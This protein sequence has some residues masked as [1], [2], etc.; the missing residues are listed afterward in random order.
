MKNPL[1]KRF[2]RE[3]LGDF[4]KYAVIFILLV[5]MIGYCSGFFVAGQSMSIAYDESFELYNIEDGHV[6]FT[7]ELNKAQRKDIENLGITLY[8]NYYYDTSFLNDTTIRL[9]VQRDEVNKICL[10]D[11]ELP[12]HGEIGLDR[13]YAVN[14]NLSIGDTI[15]DG[16]NTYTISGLVALSD[17]SALFSDNSDMMFDAVNFGVAVLT[18]EDFE[19]ISNIPV[20][21]Y[22][23]KWNQ[24]IEDEKELHSLNEDL[25]KEINSIV[26]VKDFIA[27]EDNQAITFTGEDIGGDSQMVVVFLYMVIVIVAFVMT[28]TINNTIVKESSVIGT[29]RATGYT[30]KELV[31]HYATLPILVSIASAVIGNIIGY[32]FMVDLNADLYYS[33]YSLPTFHVLF[34][35]S[36]FI[37][38]TI[39]PLIL[40]VVIVYAMLW[41]AL[42]L[43]PLQFIRKDLRRKKKQ[44]TLKLNHHIPFF[45]RFRTRVILSNMPNYIVLFFGI[46]FSNLLLYF[47]LMLPDALDNYKNKIANNLL[48]EYQTMLTVPSDVLYNSSEIETAIKYMNFMNEVET[49]NPTAE[50]FSAYSLQIPQSATKESV[51]IYGISINSKYVSIDP[52]KI[53]VSSA[54][55]KKYKVSIG[56]EIT[57]KEEYEDKNYIFHVDEIYNYDGAIAIFMDQT[58]LNKTFGYNKDFFCGYFS[59][60]PITDINEDYIGNVIDLQELTKVSTQLDVSMGEMMKMVEGFALLIFIVVTYLLSKTIIE[61]N[62]SNIS[63]TKILGYNNK[64]ISL[65]YIVATGIMVILFI[66]LSIPILVELITVIWDYYLINMFSGYFAMDV[67]FIVYVKLILYGI[68][69]YVLLSALQ[70]RK[71]AKI[72]LAEALKDEE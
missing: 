13:M 6:T 70:Y 42:S 19:S 5:T 35:P 49:D 38:T 28:I 32:T 20:Y 12:K 71:I 30:R 65:L 61:R 24:T 56:D 36:A 45:S 39:I 67:A 37:I 4:G 17:Y 3:F 46:L 1:N 21:E 8:E 58:L 53:Y 69:A 29:L 44:K 25:A 60:T 50:K 33:S 2:K 27:R 47:G 48:S 43:S 40:I 64:E 66:L 15:S 34:N 63:M 16:T 62:A 23:Y 68:G 57:L 55:A 52:T 54:Y 7:K 72:N 10:M 51:T 11:G 14:N 41:R 18:Q 22:A 26:S 31:I 9:F 59:Q